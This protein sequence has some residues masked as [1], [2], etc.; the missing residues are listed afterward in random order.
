LSKFRICSSCKDIQIVN[1][2][3]NPLLGYYKA[4]LGW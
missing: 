4:W 3:I 1:T 2:H